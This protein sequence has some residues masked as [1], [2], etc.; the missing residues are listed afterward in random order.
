MTRYLIFPE[1]D[2]PDVA[3]A[4]H[5]VVQQAKNAAACRCTRG[6]REIMDDPAS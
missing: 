1:K 3:K 2:L 6:V 4:T 5:E